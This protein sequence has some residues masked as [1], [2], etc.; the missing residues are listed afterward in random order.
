VG[1]FDGVHLGHQ[2]IIA[3]LNKVAAEKGGE[4]VVVT[5]EPHPRMVLT[6]HDKAVRLINIAKRKYERLENAGVQHLIVLPF[7]L[8]FSRT[9]WQVFIKEVIVDQ[10]HAAHLV[11]GYDHRFGAHRQGSHDSMLE[12]AQLYGFGVEEV[13]ELLIDGIEVSSTRIRQALNGGLIREAN[14]LLGYEYSITGLVVHGNRIGHQLGFPTANIETD[15]KFKLI[16][17]N[18]VYASRVEWQ[19]RFYE[20]MSNIGIRPTINDLRFAV[21]VNIFDFDQDIYGECLTVYFV[22][23]IRDEIKFA[24]LQELSAQLTTDKQHIKKLLKE[25]PMFGIIE[26]TAL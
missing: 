24:S 15:D 2:Q 3:R 16:A 8:E 25:N 11:I 17:A 23:R 12:M 18:G 5:F 1:T 13:D 6:P 9:P 26:K 21:E 10:I 14:R 19:G 22:D 20:G 4:S 7:T